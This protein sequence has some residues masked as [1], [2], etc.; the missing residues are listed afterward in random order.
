MMINERRVTFPVQLKRPQ[1]TS[2]SY[3]SPSRMPFY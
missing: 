3:P 2:S 1:S